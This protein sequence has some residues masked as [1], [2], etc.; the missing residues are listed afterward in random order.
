MPVLPTERD[1]LERLVEWG[2]SDERVRALVL[3]SSRARQDATVDVLSDYDVVVATPDAAALAAD[4]GVAQAA[5][6]EPAARWGDESEIHGLTTFFRGVVYADGT[7]VD[8]TFWPIE[9]FERV[10][11]EPE[12]PAML[13]VGYRV[14]L[15]EDDLTAAWPT[16]TYRTHIPVPP[17]R[18]EYDATVEEFW[19]SATYAA[20]SLWRGE[21]VFAK[22]VLDHDLFG[23]LLPMLEWRVELDHGWSLRP[24]AKGRG[25]ERLLPPDRS[26]VLA[27]TYIGPDPGESWD[28]LFR[29]A[30]LFREV[31]SEVGDALGYA[32]PS[33]VDELVSAHLAAVRE[34]PPKE[35][36]QA[37][38]M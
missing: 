16:A 8:F 33:R 9:L 17:T 18:E 37:R 19:W 28:A 7:K 20:K 30:V 34:L 35:A 38:E 25:I 23:A 36:P 1:V 32:Y 12:L 10:G 22:H 14:L 31:A 27:A 2:R 4:A 3:T 21:T 13:D 5:Y 29:L 6:G 24:G 15:D 26:A 11:R